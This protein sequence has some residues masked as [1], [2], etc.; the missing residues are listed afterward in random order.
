MC[1]FAVQKRV[2]KNSSPLLSSPFR[3]RCRNQDTRHA[4]QPHLCNA[5]GHLSALQ[6]IQSCSVHSLLCTCFAETLQLMAFRIFSAAAACAALGA[7]TFVNERIQRRIEASKHTHSHIITYNV[8]TSNQAG[9]AATEAYLLSTPVALARHVVSVAC[10]D[11]DKHTL[12]SKRES[13]R[14]T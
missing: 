6:E 8:S 1:A 13:A 9:S 10:E 3:R 4:M 7:S 14:D 5:T 12:V 2:L 11:D